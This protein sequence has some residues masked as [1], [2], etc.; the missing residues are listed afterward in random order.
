MSSGS[1][2]MTRFWPDDNIL[3]P[4]FILVYWSGKGNQYGKCENMQNPNSP[5]ECHDCYENMKM[6]LF[7]SGNVSINIGPCS[8]R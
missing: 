6:V 2:E 3:H 5:D 8:E 7:L 1:G 4:P